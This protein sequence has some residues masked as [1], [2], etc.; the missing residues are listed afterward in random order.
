VCGYGKDTFV[1]EKQWKVTK[2]PGLY[3]L[4]YASLDET[5]AKNRFQE[6]IGQHPDISVQ[7]W[8]G[9]VPMA[10]YIPK[11]QYIAWFDTDTVYQTV[12]V[13]LEGPAKTV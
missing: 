12:P 6:Y 9:I 13:M 11:Y 2:G 3:D 8:L 4:V 5:Q 1:Y 7:L 10:V